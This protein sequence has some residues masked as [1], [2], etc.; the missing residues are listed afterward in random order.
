MSGFRKKNLSN[1]IILF[2]AVLTTADLTATVILD[3]KTNKRLDSLQESAEAS[4]SDNEKIMYNSSVLTL[5]ETETGQEIIIKDGTPNQIDAASGEIKAEPSMS[6]SS[7]FSNN[8]EYSDEDFTAICRVVEAE[9]HGADLNSKMHIV[10]VILNRSA[11]PE[12]PDSV[13]DVCNQPGQFVKRNDVEQSTVDAVNE[14]VSSSDTTQGA[15][16][17]CTCR[18]CW[19]E[20]NK[21]FLFTDAVGHDF[22]R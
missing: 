18:G 9:A 21:E 7:G 12:F 10:H 19:T 1:I 5:P 2:T 22:Y 6:V 16:F 15:L 13:Q 8:T 4:Y 3:C 17:F 14:A 11:S 20:R